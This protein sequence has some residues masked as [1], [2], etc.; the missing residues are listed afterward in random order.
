[1]V[2]EEI[3]SHFIYNDRATIFVEFTLCEDDV[4]GEHELEIPMEDLEEV[5][6]L[7]NEREWFDEGDEGME[8]ITLKNDIDE[9]QLKEGLSIYVNQNRQVLNY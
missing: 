7:F 8:I 9:S 2:I 3:H 6:D 1:M 5:C 4:C